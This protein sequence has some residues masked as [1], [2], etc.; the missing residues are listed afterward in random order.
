MAYEPQPGTV[1]HKVVEHMRTLPAGT[2]LSASALGEVVDQNN[3]VV[4]MSLAPARKHG[5][6]KAR[7]E[8]RLVFWS[9]GDGTPEPLPHDYEADEPL[10][11]PAPIR[12]KAP[13]PPAVCRT[14]GAR[15]GGPVQCS[16]VGRWRPD[17]LRRAGERGRQHHAQGARRRCG[18]A[19]AVGGARMTAQPVTIHGR[20]CQLL[21]APGGYAVRDQSGVVVAQAFSRFLAVAEA[22]K[23]LA[24]PQ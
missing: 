7:K 14:R 19:S 18:E 10:H 4:I 21:P 17:H 11:A 3:N 12:T 24:R 23:A 5:L 13:T 20:Q 9:L 8:G 22:A 1:A 15:G 16:P 6:V 2:E